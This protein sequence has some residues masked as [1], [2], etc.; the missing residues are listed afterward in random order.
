MP[1]IGGEE[2]TRI[3]RSIEKEHNLPP[4]DI[5]TCSS[6]Y[7]GAFPGAN[8][9]LSKP[10]VL[11]EFIELVQEKRHQQASNRPQSLKPGLFS[12]S[13]PREVKEE[14]PTDQSTPR[15]GG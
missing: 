14:P 1:R 5:R 3:I 2:A 7:E 15:Q 13:K 12:G 9:R 11:K 10:V 6:T 8:G 4:A